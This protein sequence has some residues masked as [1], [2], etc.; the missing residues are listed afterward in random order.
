MKTKKAIKSNTR[1]LKDIRSFVRGIAQEGGFGSKDID[2][3][4]LAVDE[5]CSN[6]M[7]HAYKG[8]LEK[9]I[10][11]YGSA[12]HYID[13]QSNVSMKEEKKINTMITKGVGKLPVLKNNIV[14]TKSNRFFGFINPGKEV[15]KNKDYGKDE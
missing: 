2:G 5:A 15:S 4:V 13:S 7:R 14:D 10:D 3:I 6:I 1:N 11:N 8:D 9:D 12:F